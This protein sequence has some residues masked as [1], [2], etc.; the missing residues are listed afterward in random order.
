MICGKRRRDARPWLPEGDVVL[1]KHTTACPRQNVSS[2]YARRL[3]EARPCH[4]PM[5]DGGDRRSARTFCSG[6]YILVRSPAAAFT[7][8]RSS[9][10]EVSWAPHGTVGYN[11]L[12]AEMPRGYSAV[13]CDE[14]TGIFAT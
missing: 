5:V 7:D 1:L 11:E 12:V 4:P 13:I 10:P 2:A 8:A 3:G 14:D 9:P 6:R